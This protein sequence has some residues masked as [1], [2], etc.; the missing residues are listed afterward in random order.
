MKLHIS[1]THDAH[2]SLLFLVR[3]IV[4]CLLL[5]RR[6]ICSP[7]L[8]IIM[9]LAVITGLL[10]LIVAGSGSDS[11]GTPAGAPAVASAGCPFVEVLLVTA[12]CLLAI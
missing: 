9:T 7:L 12:G 8:C 1:T 6:Q 5:A 11:T 10:E 3:W 2:K 4:G